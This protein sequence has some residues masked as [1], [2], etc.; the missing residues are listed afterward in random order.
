M[1]LL[2]T[3]L[4][5]LAAVA[6]PAFAAKKTTYSYKGKTDAKDPIRFKAS[7]K[8]VTGF[9]TSWTGY[10]ESHRTFPAKTALKSVKL[11]RKYDS[12]GKYLW[13][14]KKGNYDGGF[15]YNGADYTA[16]YSYDVFASI[17]KHVADGG[18][19]GYVK[20]FDSTGSQVDQ[21]ATHGAFDQNGWYTLGG[22]NGFRL[23]GR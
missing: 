1:R 4:I 21:C 2:A 7:D 13:F 6:S 23:K 20:I 16:K 15:S 14:E 18:F 19:Y 10:C 11:V 22:G 8:K 3:A 5:A 17:Q 12:S 9:V